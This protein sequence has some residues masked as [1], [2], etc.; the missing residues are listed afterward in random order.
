M[1]NRKKSSAQSRKYEKM[2]AKNLRRTMIEEE[3]Y[4][5]GWNAASAAVPDLLTATA[6]AACK[7]RDQ[8]RKDKHGTPYINH[9]IGVVRLMSEVGGIQYKDSLIAGMLHDTVEDTETTP[10]EIEDLFGP[11]VSSL[12][13]EVSDD[14]NLEKAMRKQLQIDHAPHLSPQAKI[15]KLADK[16]ANVTDISMSP[17][18]GWDLE[19]RIEYMIWAQRVVA[20]CRGS[21]AALENLFDR[22]LIEAKQSILLH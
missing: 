19:R 8:R 3:G 10:G 13:M 16:I 20:G 15:I 22:R 18:I 6:F 17:P 1:K 11:T 4:W 9:P 5:K 2:F 14:K 12:V 7:H 21:N